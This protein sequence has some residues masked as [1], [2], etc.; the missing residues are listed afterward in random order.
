MSRYKDWLYKY[1]DVLRLAV[2]EIVTYLILFSPTIT[3]ALTGSCPRLTNRVNAWMLACSAATFLIL[4]YV[5]QLLFLVK[6]TI[7]LCKEMKPPTRS[8]GMGLLFHLLAHF[9][10]Y[11]IIQNLLIVFL[12][13]ETYVYCEVD[14]T[15][16]QLVLLSV[17]SV[18]I[19]LTPVV[20]ILTFLVLKH[21]RIYDLCVVYCTDYLSYLNTIQCNPNTAQETKQSIQTALTKFEFEILMMESHQYNLSRSNVKFAYPLRVILLSLPNAVCLI[22]LITFVI[23]YSTSRFQTPW[24]TGLSLMFWVCIVLSILLLVLNNIQLILVLLIYPVISI[25]TRIVISLG[26]CMHSI[27]LQSL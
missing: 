11:R 18:L 5:T 1:S 17:V 27:L 21:G 4:V 25:G 10:V 15:T 12:I 7:Y 19:Y 16:C 14:S 20:G 22:A 6:F 13:T 23:I 9:I 8:K 3:S 24:D 2:S 26:R